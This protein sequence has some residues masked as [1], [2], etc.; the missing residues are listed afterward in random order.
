MKKNCASSRLF[1][2]IVIMA[3]HRM[4]CSLQH[5]VNLYV[6]RK[7]KWNISDEFCNVCVS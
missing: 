7:W 6:K 3:I 4:L 2:I 5:C 1:T